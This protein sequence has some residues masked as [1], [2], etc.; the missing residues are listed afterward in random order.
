MTRLAPAYQLRHTAKGHPRLD[1]VCSDLM[2]LLQQSGSVKHYSQR[3]DTLVLTFDI[4][5]PS[6][7]AD[8]VHTTAHLQ[9]HTLHLTLPIAHPHF[10][11]FDEDELKQYLA[12]LVLEAIL[13]AEQCDGTLCAQE[14]YHSVKF[15]LYRRGWFTRMM[16][17][18]A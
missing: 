5:T 7:F 9:G 2:A 18:A 8:R 1:A 6:R 11:S 15:F 17:P 10:L 12:E 4:L 16:F 14:L 3:L 13:I